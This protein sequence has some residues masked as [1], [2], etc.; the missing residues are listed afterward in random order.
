MWTNV[1]IDAGRTRYGQGQLTEAGWRARH[2]RRGRWRSID[3]TVFLAKIVP[4]KVDVE[5][6]IRGVSPQGLDLASIPT[7]ESGA[8]GHLVVQGGRVRMAVG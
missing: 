5:L 7:Q 1:S 8:E 4:I 2:L 6:R 3:E